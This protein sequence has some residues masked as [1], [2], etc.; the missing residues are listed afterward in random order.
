[1]LLLLRWG[2]KSVAE[3]RNVSQQYKQ[4][5]IPLEVMWSD[6]DHMDRWEHVRCVPECVTFIE[7]H[8]S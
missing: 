2:Y 8:A 7:L 6:I 1:L 3:L 5:G 4:A